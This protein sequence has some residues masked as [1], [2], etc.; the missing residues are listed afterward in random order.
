M[1]Q[2]L[3]TILI[4]L[5]CTCFL[6]AGGIIYQQLQLHQ[7]RN[8]M[9]GAAEQVTLD[10]MLGR[11]NQINDQIDGLVGRKL[12]GAEDFQVAQQVMVSRIDA[13]Q[14]T[15]KQASEAAQHVSD[16]A[17]S[18][19]DLLALQAEVQAVSESVE[20]LR[21]AKQQQTSVQL[22]KPVKPP[23]VKPIAPP[24]PPVPPPFQIIGIEYRGGEPFLT[25]APPGSTRL[26]QIYLV[27][28][29]DTVV[30]SAWRL[31]GID[32]KSARFDVAGVSRTINVQ[33]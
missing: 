21:K 26:S 16:Q 6:L 13:V 12:I 31:S 3:Q 8:A 22:E 28:P 7:L 20:N 9:E 17:A 14:A 23:V 15:A 11:M 5:V 18:S 29:G 25:V 32:G 19:R 24:P 2:R 4:C 33:P 27:R 1:S 10:G 30:G